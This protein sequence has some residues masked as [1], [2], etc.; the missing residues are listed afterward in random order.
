M[1]NPICSEEE[2]PKFSLQKIIPTFDPL[3]L[4][5]LENLKIYLWNKYQIPLR[6]DSRLVY[7]Y[8]Y[9]MPETTLESVC[10]ELWYTKLCH[11]YTNY[12]KICQETI[13]SI[14]YSLMNS[15]SHHPLALSQAQEHI[16]NFVIPSIQMNCICQL[17]NNSEF[18]SNIKEE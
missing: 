16:K 18:L 13:P 8:L 17:M 11:E 12:Q 3:L 1:S 6:D 2:L 14:R 10:Q 4:K 7:Y 15:H 9:S 5:K